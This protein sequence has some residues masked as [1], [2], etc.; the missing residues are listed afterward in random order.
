METHDRENEIAVVGMSVRVPGARDTAEFWR[1]LCD[2]VESIAV[3]S[4]D[5]LRAHGISE[6]VLR[7]P[8]YVPAHGVLDEAYAFD[9]AFFGISPR[10]AQVMDPQQRV[11]L[12]CA[13]SALEDAGYD[14]QRFPGAIGVFA[15]SGSTAHLSRVL[16]HPD[17]VATV[18]ASVVEFANAKDFLTTRVSYKLGL[19]GPS[20]AIQTACSTSLVAIH[21]ACQ[22][23]LGGECDLALAGGVTILTDQVRG[24]QYQEGGILSPDGHCRAFDAR[25]AGMVSGSGAGVVLLKRLTDALRDGDAIQA[26]IKGSAIN[27][28]GAGK[29]GFT[30]PSVAG[31]ARA[32]AEALAVAGVDPA[33]V[34]YVETHGT[35][36][37]LGD[38]IEIAALTEVF[39]AST[40]RTRCCAL[41]AVKTNI[42]H[43][44]C[45]AGVAGLIKTV[46]ALQH[47]QLAPTL[48]FETPNPETALDDSPFYVN[49]ALTDWARHGTPR[50]AGVS[51]FGI[52]GTNAHVVLEEAPEVQRPAAPDADHGAQLI[53]L[54]A[55]SEGALQRARLNLSQH[56][57]DHPELTLADVAFTLQEGRAA[58]PYRWTTVARDLASAGCALADPGAHQHTRRAADRQP[59]VAF[60]FPGQGTQYAGMGR[61]LYQREPIFRRTLDQCLEA[62]TPY[63]SGDLRSLLF[64][65]D[66]DT[67]RAH[68]LLQQT[69]YT[70]PALFAVE[71]A[72]ATLWMSWGVRPDA[73]IGHSIGEYVAAC[74]AGVFSLEQAVRLVALRGRLMYELPP[75]AMLA[76]PLSEADAR[77]WLATRP[78]LSLAAVNAASHVVVSGPADEIAALEEALAPHNVSARRLH[79][80]HAFHSAAMDPMLAAFGEA[81]RTARPEAPVM[82]FLSNV[83]GDW[84]TDEQAT[85]ASYWVRHLRETVRFADGMGRLLEDP[86]RVLLEVGPGDTLGLFARRHPS[87]DGTRVV[88]RSLPGPTHAGEGD[89]TI[90]AAAGV[91]WTA[92]VEVDWRAL[93]GQAKAGRVQLPTYPFERTEYRVPPLRD[94]SSTRAAASGVITPVAQTAAASPM[95]AAVSASRLSRIITR[96]TAVFASL[97]GTDAARLHP[98]S[99]FLELGADSLLL[100]QASR[101]IES[102]CGVRVPFR[103]LLEGLST[104]ERL[105]A[106]LERE[107]SVEIE[108]ES[109]VEIERVASHGP[110]RPVR[111]SIAEGGGF[112]DRQSRYVD[113]FVRRYEA[114]TRQSKA[115]AAE[116]RSALADNRASLNFRQA[117]KE[118]L[119]PVVGARSEGSRLWDLDGNEYIDFTLGFGVHF[120]GHRP[121]FIMRAV[122]EQLRRGVHLGPQ[123]DLAGPV[124]RLFRELTGLER[125]TFCNTGSEAVMTA[126]RIARTATGRQQ[127][128]LFEGAYH[129]CFDGVLARRAATADPASLGRARPAAPGTTQGMVDDVVVLP[130]GTPEAMAWLRAHATD[131]AAVLVEPVQNHNPEWQ[132]WE[133]LRELRSLTARTGTVLIFDEMIT[134]FRL[135]PRG[136]QGWY[137][138]EADLATYGKV[139]GGG[140]PLG[141]VAGRADL[142]D[143]IDG[144]AWT[145]GDDSYP[146]AN[147]TFFAGT[148][149]KHPVTMAASYAVLQHLREQGATLYDDLNARTARLV[150]ALRAV[151]D[152]AGT[153]V[154]ILHCGS[155]FRFRF[156]QRNRL[157]DLL[158]YHL[159]ARGIYVWE[160]R[161]CFVS[162]AHTDDDC[163]RFVRACRESLE[164]MREGGFLPD[165]IPPVATAAPRRSFPLTPAQRQIWIHAQLDA[166]TSRAYHEQMVFGVRGQVD[167]DALRAALRDVM[168]HHEA[169]RTVF[170]ASGEMQHVLPDAPVAFRVEPVPASD[171]RADNRAD[172]RDALDAALH[173]A[174]AEPFDLCTGPLVRVHV[175]PLA[176]ERQ[177]VQIVFHH[178]AMDALGAGVFMRDLATAYRARRDGGGTP[179]LPA[180]M[181]FSEYAS[182]IAA[183]LDEES[184]REAEWQSRFDQATPLELPAR[185]PRSRLPTGRAAQATLRI[186]GALASRLK[187][188]GRREGCTLFTTLLGG[189][190]AALHR[191]SSQFDLIV[192]I[193]SAGRPFPGAESLV[194][195]CVD[196]LPIRSR[197][198]STTELLPF[199]QRVRGLML[200]AYEHELFSL[201]RLVGKRPGPAGAAPLVSVSFNLEPASAAHDRTEPRFAGH[202]IEGVRTRTLFTKF[203]ITIDAVEQGDDIVWSWI[204]NEDLFEREIIARLLRA[205]ERVLEQ[206]AASAPVRVSELNL[207]D[208][209]EQAQLAAWSEGPHADAGEIGTHAATPVPA[210]VHVAQRARE[211]PG[212]VALLHAGGVVTYGALDDRAEQLARQLRSRGVG[213]DATVGVCLERT[214]DLVVAVLGIWKAGGVFVPLDPSYP[215][216][217][218]AAMA[219]DAGMSVV[220]A[221]RETG[222]IVSIID[223]TF[224]S[225]D[226]LPAP[227]GGEAGGDAAVDMA[228]A[229]L[230]YII[231]TSG[232]TGRP[233]GVLVEHGSLANLLAATRDAFEVRRD[234][235]MPALASY[236]FDIWLFEILLPLTSGAAV[237]LVARERV[238]DVPALLD[239]VADATL[240]HAVPALMRQ[241]VEAARETPDRLRRLR[242][243]FVGGDRVPSDLLIEMRAIW[244]ATRTYVLYGPTEGT[245]LASACAV[246]ADGVVDGNLLGRPLG[247][248]RVHVCDA[249]GQPQPPGIP[250]ELMI[251][252]HGVARGYGHQPRLTAERFVPDPF[253]GTGT[254][255]Y[256]TGDRARWRADG[257]LEFL[258]RLD[259]QVKIRGFR[260]EPAEIEAVLRLHPDVHDARVVVSHDSGEPQ[261]VAYLVGDV[262]LEA[263]RADLRERLPAY[264]IPSAFVR[265][266]RLP[267]NPNGKLDVA[268]L[269]SPVSG[270][271]GDADSPRTPIE[272]VLAG[273]WADV[274][275]LDR[276]GVSQDFFA[277]GGHSL[278]AMKVVSRVREVLAVELP[279]RTLF[280]QATVSALAERVEALRQGD[281]PAPLLPRLVAT[282]RDGS[283]PPLSFAQERLWFLDRLEPGTT[284]Y[285]MLAPRRLTGP[286]DVDALE[287]ALGEIVRRHEVLRTT[288]AEVGGPPVQ[289][290]APWTGL[291]LPVIDLSSRVAADA[292]AAERAAAM[293]ALTREAIQEELSRPFDLMTGPLLRSTLLRI[294]VEEHVLLVGMH[295]IVSDGWSMGVLFREL[296]VLYDAFRRG[297]ASPLPALPVQYADYAVWQRAYLQ[298]DALASQLAY[299]RAQ[300]AGAPALLALPTDHPRPAL[301]RAAGA[302]EEIA[303]PQELMAQLQAWGRREGAT[304]YMVGLAAFQLVL[305]SYADTDD[306]VVGSPIAGRPHR[307]LEDLIGFF[308]NTLVLRTDLSGDPSV[309]ELVRR[310]RDVTLAAYAHQDVP[311]EQLVGEL[312]PVRSL[313]QSPLFQVLFSLVEARDLA[314]P[315]LAGLDVRPLGLDVETAKFDLSLG[316]VTR[317]DGGVAGLS[318]RT[319]LFTRDTIVRLLQQFAAVLAQMGAAPEARIS[320]LTRLDATAR[321][322]VLA[323]GQGPAAMACPPEATLPA[324]FEAQVARTPTAIAVRHEHA[325]LTYAALNARANQ[326]AHLLRAAGVGPDVRVAIGLDRGLDLIV[327]VL[328]VLKA[329]GAYVPLDP[330]YPAARLAFM[331]AD[332]EARV[333]L[334]QDALRAALPHDPAV[335][336]ISLD[337]PDVIARLAAAPVTNPAWPVPPAALAYVIYTS[338]STGVPKGVAIPHAS[339]VAFLAWAATLVDAEDLAGVLASTSV[340]FDLS[341]FE[342]FLPL[343][344]GGLVIL[345]ADALALPTSAAADAVRLV[346]TVPSAMAA[347]LE[348]EGLPAGVRTVQLAGEPLRADLVDALYARG[349]TRVVDLY[350]PSE[351]TTYST[352]ALRQPHG[353]ETIGRPIAGTQAYVVDA[354]GQLVPMGVPG[355]LWLAGAGLARGY[356][357]RPG[358]TAERFVPDPFAATPGARAY[359]TGDRVRWRPDGTLAYLG[360]RDAQVKIRGF[361]IELGEVEAAVRQQPG[362]ADAVVLARADGPGERQL[363]A[364]VVGDADVAALRTALRGGVPAHLVPAAFVLLDRLPRTPNGKLDRQALPAPTFESHRPAEGAASE[365][366]P[367]EGVIAGIW[368]DVLRHDRVGLADNFFELGGHSLLAMRV[369]SRLRDMLDVEIPLRTLFEC[370]TVAELAVQV[371]ALRHGAPTLPAIAP[372][373][374]LGD[375]PLSFA[376]ERLW[377]L[378]RLEPN[379]ATYNLIAPRRLRG[380]LDVPALERALAEIVRR[381]EALRT[382]F[383]SV[384]GTP[385]QVI[386]PFTGFDLSHLDLS[387]LDD[388][389]RQAAARGLA[390]AEMMEPF[391]LATGPLFRAKLIRCDAED[392]V[393]LVGMHHIVSDGWSMGILFRELAVLYDAFR[394]G[395]ASP[396]PALPVQYADYAVWQRAYLQGGAL[397]SQLAYWRAQLAGA[398]ALLALPTD[399]PRPA[400]QR[401]AGAYEEIALPRALVAQLQAWGRREGATLY[402]VGLA[403][404]Q[405][406]LASYADT[407]D[408]VVGSP[409]AGRPHRALED[410]IGFFVNTLVLRTDLSGDPSVRELV[411][412]VRDVTL[413]A[414]AHQDV[415]FEQLV[416]ELQPVRSLGQSPLFQVLFSLVEA[417]DLA[418]PALAGLDVRPLGLDVETAKFDLSL[419]LVTRA[420]G[421]VAGLSYRTDLF[422]RDTIVRLLQQF[423]AVLAQMCAAPEARISELTLLDDAARAEVLAVGQ[424]PAALA[425]PPEETLP[426]LF[427]AQVA[428]TP[429]AIAVRHEH[430]VLTY[431]AL[432]T[433]ANQLAHLLRDAGVGPDVRVAIGL[434][435]G[436]DLIVAVLAVLK[437]GGAYVPLDPTYPAARLAFMLADAEARV[438]VTQDA[439][440]AARPSAPT[441]PVISLDDP[442]VIARLAAAP[443]TNP[444]WPVPPAALAYVIYT[445]GSTGVPKGVAIP[446]A[447]AVA[448]LAWAATLVDA[449]DLAGVLASTSVC[450]D[451]SIFELFLPLTRGGL[452]ILVADALAL[453]T[454]TAADAVRLVNTVPSAMAALLETEGL[455][456]GVRTVHLAGEPLRADLVDALYARG[457]T[458]VVDLY[459]P[460][461]STTYSTA[462]LRQPHGPETIGRPIA[463][464]QAYVVDAAGQLGPMGVPGELWLA[465][466]GLARGYLGRPGLTA[467]RFVPDPFAATP[468]ARA[469]RT[470]DRVRWRPDGT[471]AY[472]GR[473][474]AQ[475]KIRGF[476]IE[477]G[478]VEAAV[479]QQPG[480]ADAVV[481]A[482]ADGPGERQLVAYVVGDVDVAALRTGLRGCVPAHMVP[483]AFVRL[484]RL[485]RTPNGKL[486]RQALPAPSYSQSDGEIHAPTNFIEVQLIQIWEELLGVDV[487]DPTRNFFELGGHSL[488]ATRLLARIKRR[489]GCDLPVSTLFAGATVRQMAKAILDH[490]QLTPTPPSTIVRMQPQ[491][492]LPPLFCIHPGDRRVLIY[493]S[494]V[495]HFGTDQPLLGLQDLG[496]DLSRP[497]PQI[498]AEYIEAMRSVRPHGP[499]DLLGWSFGGFVAYEIASQLER[500]GETVSF[501]GLMDTIHPDVSRGWIK[502]DLEML[503]GIGRDV[504]TRAR[505]TFSIDRRELEGLDWHEQFD[506]VLAALHAQGVPA[507]FDIAAYQDYFDTL[508]QRLVSIYR[509]VPGPFSGPITLFRASVSDVD[510]DP[511]FAHKSDEDRWTLGW[512]RV[513]SMVDVHP[514]PGAHSTM[515]AEPHVRVLVPL[516]RQRLAEARARVEA[517]S[518][519]A[520]EALTESVCP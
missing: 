253:G 212:A 520:R 52:G 54:S 59:P 488:L 505:R 434:D 517:G 98:A 56:L 282:A 328:A 1:N 75:G 304:L 448:F 186:G 255:L 236:A 239:D 398:P 108:R 71:Y 446:H 268:A 44:D 118:L 440:R 468:G 104:I 100:M 187:V 159:I 308:V 405:L 9:A 38:P 514:V 499:Y 29:V 136:A 270:S 313:G 450:F 95:P 433:R 392:H 249:M 188:V 88:A 284:T 400:L 454:S 174:L 219:A 439:R 343:T 479:R 68:A 185:G 120:F 19:R 430:A 74:L 115:Y 348:T 230:A 91:L 379:S 515:G 401:A 263:P 119:Y 5:D 51:S 228:S 128:V 27:N 26:V 214:P 431:A 489:W 197:I 24:Y 463:G 279:L 476:R 390:R 475:V 297:A 81:V 300:L 335:S 394:R 109:P 437:A 102:T 92:G 14:P 467:E 452:V 61:E 406:V 507:S 168:A 338:G 427:E 261:L 381:H 198:E 395:A 60:L 290:I 40:D 143:A 220:I 423:A 144:G 466:A 132:P 367:I 227:P 306:V 208:R 347:L 473:R 124:A 478:E 474:D 167:V 211:T 330:T 369:V 399:H 498:A 260:I 386:A 30:A 345:V 380:P 142:M 194:G 481:L 494:M 419:G 368:A 349:V 117:T 435:R 501:L 317:A 471:L 210:H 363:V 8:S 122:E 175:H 445:S 320:A 519:V 172:D 112:T 292:D 181:Q 289:Q 193:P 155:L 183:R 4:P 199:L 79:T 296:A 469:Y 129:G 173:T 258:G 55:K 484:D 295:H 113:A 449:E 272:E 200:D 425:C 294:D 114:R 164:A 487:T 288:C 82:R 443:V 259:A 511:F 90:L 47:R 293:R 393:L 140:F 196:V 513:S 275:H 257:R 377:F 21:L 137:G 438:L 62:S 301:Q 266:D 334:T 53:V 429:T 83:S 209:V 397:A 444:A 146:M 364:Y 149:C 325:G 310:V 225:I 232:S 303:L 355:E 315:A 491:G 163:D 512:C 495:R 411:R 426:A 388:A 151:C 16:R 385:T 50:R 226:D 31:Q 35:G 366:T 333:L 126:L 222:S 86:R 130:Y 49:V 182:L 462:A 506:R 165:R 189:L 250:G 156:D 396:L 357:G 148:F 316:L 241:I 370:P 302:Y 231:Y 518:P 415:P 217:R 460:S 154:R 180:A 229:Q 244:P 309:R 201:A 206:I 376:Q 204:F 58:H 157:G 378:D 346:N 105:A 291:S 20:L 265:L 432:N 323:V 85:E 254:R 281:T 277:L 283:P 264:M 73:M 233:K 278:L 247:G 237:R 152:D 504:A 192:G 179:A 2:G 240:L 66:E 6:D 131:L 205:T 45:A 350:G 356:L 177:V 362:V 326:L 404:F 72:L 344:R 178:I 382:R 503:I 170:D 101:T 42:G 248:V 287:R 436:L 36:T 493:V 25:A 3:F 32:I 64:P 134:G 195:H 472:L 314:A 273:I 299:W 458:R 428:R 408:V 351:S 57:A 352:A 341:I 145:F 453:P 190:L 337:D 150:A 70:Q 176:V 116:H 391:D 87:N 238:L 78:R 416:G 267:L 447:S 121:A 138:I 166:D 133:F 483:A 271:H 39:R 457:V 480:V 94:S 15:G 262:D 451:L 171:D 89:L 69:R 409:I 216:Q 322:E 311:F 285:N 63:V 213:P 305:A 46:L 276:V 360:R 307:A 191:L 127:V 256:R 107:S 162:T 28:D 218:L 327:A 245:I 465:G 103:Q 442:D 387:E 516:M 470:G 340:C 106:H 402:M 286:L 37:A 421:G 374:R 461:E 420:D 492:S 77:T 125:V 403:A 18:G 158:L 410:L 13:W 372:V 373:A 280:E 482:R 441:V 203:D 10:E 123:S 80:S 312:Q 490:Q 477:L 242:I 43:L 332:A 207:L 147:Q 67:D 215:P 252:G 331:L 509:Y 319:D 336:V 383:V 12:E 358:L 141:V 384:E 243:A 324:L 353:P 96:I 318:Y 139:I 93:R 496:E 502:D 414:Y 223:A 97:L 251:G 375:M 354:A 361:R 359:R 221:T 246:T 22:S 7:D 99:T 161:A 329:G 41:G 485:P 235:V 486:D 407:D 456:A 135:H 17:L 234:D 34:S 84:I 76:L 65:A 110:H 417:R 424:G 500:Q 298:G 274:L 23:L 389:D 342:L 371:E 464:T 365:P 184:N 412:R 48:H 269:P 224:V 413:A 497:I 321:A 459:G 202:A 418:A 455:P 11:F 33:T 153:G 169:L 422:T 339:A 160:G 508:K 111:E 510:R